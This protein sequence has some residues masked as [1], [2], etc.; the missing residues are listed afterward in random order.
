MLTFYPLKNNHVGVYLGRAPSRAQ[1][2]YEKVMPFAR[3]Q[4]AL[5]VFGIFLLVFAAVELNVLLETLE[6]WGGANDL[7]NLASAIFMTCWLLGWSIAVLFILII[8]LGMLYGRGLLLVYQGR[9]EMQLGTSNMGVLIRQEASKITSI[10][11]VDPPAKSVF[12]KEGKQLLISDGD[13]ITTTPVGSNMTQ[14]DLES[15]REAVSVNKNVDAKLDPQVLGIAR[16]AKTDSTA[17]EFVEPPAEFSGSII[18]LVLANLAPLIG[19]LM[20][21]WDLSEIMVLYWVETAVLLLYQIA[22]H[23]TISPVLGL[24]AS[25]FSIASAAGFMALHFLFIWNIFVAGGFASGQVRDSE[26][27]EVFD[28]IALLW[29]AIV[30]L[31]ISHGYSFYSN[32]WPRRTLYRQGKIKLKNLMERIVLMHVT[33]IFG[34]FLVFATGHNFAGVL[35]LIVLKII[36]DAFAHRKYNKKARQD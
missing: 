12:P 10:E 6:L 36:V 33:I 21:G 32:F 9:V 18:A 14:Q 29:P 13:S 35:L 20:F 17:D 4:G 15:V 23:L 19:A 31:I 25:L 34:A 26:L 3:S 30:A 5:I 16:F 11:L 8:F 27:S 7:F 1:V 24:L 2:D 22:K 28:Y